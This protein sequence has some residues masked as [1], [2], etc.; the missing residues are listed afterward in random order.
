MEAVLS[1]SEGKE[2]HGGSMFSPHSKTWTFPNLRT[3]AGPT[4]VYL[5]VEEEEEEVVSFG[6]PFRGVTVTFEVD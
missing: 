1:M 2:A 4:E 6:S 5:A 3:P